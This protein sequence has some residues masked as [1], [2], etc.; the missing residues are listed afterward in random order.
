MPLKMN[1]R[2][3]LN[4]LAVLSASTIGRKA[5]AVSTLD[6]GSAW[7]GK[8]K[9]LGKSGNVYEELGLTTVING[10]GTMTYLGGSLMRPEAEA[11]MKLASMH[12]VNI[13]DL[14]VAAGKRIAEM[15][16]LPQGYSALVTSGAASAIQ[17][18]YSG[19]L[20]GNNETSIKQIPDLTGLKSEVIIQKAH[21]SPWNHQIRATGVKMVEV[22][23]VADVHN[24]ISE[25][26]AAMHFLNLAD[27]DGQ[28]K[29]EEWLKLAHAANLPAFIDA[30][31]DT[32]PKS[33]LWDYANMGYDLISFSGGKAMRGPQCTGLLIGREE[34]IHNAA[35]NM[36][37]NEDTLGRPTKVGKEEIVG[38]LKTLELYLAEDEEVLAK[39][40]WRQLNT[41]ANRVSKI[42]GVT[43]TR[44]VPEIANNFPTIQIHLDPGKF[45]ID[46]GQVN[47]ELAS[48]KPSIVLGGGGHHGNGSIGITAI[49]LQPGED[50]IIADALWKVLR[51]HQA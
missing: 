31:A 22:E 43:V 36:S 16:K 47:R 38:M 23:T 7:S 27:P 1:R 8:I 13:N 46:A 30:A 4:A 25:R 12:F 20:T 34:M 41:I 21:R 9:G 3:F 18:G 42:E 45:S 39:E 19:I 10:Q 26:T 49:V 40:Q 32:P 33:H 50:R 44:H 2:A 14:E 11:V 24:A 6:K 5:L 15:L 48:M 35:L 17:N 29:R 37:P 51:K 28:I